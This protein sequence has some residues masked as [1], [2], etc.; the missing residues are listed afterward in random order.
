MCRE[1]VYSR[2][3]VV[4]EACLLVVATHVVVVVPPLEALLSAGTHTTR[5]DHVIHIYI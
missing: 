5:A 4:W 1:C 2:K 3:H